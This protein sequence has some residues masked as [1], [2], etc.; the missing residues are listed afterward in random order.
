MKSIHLIFF[1]LFFLT[2]CR[3]EPL[4]IEI[5]QAEP[6]AVVFSQ[7]FPD[8]FLSLVLTNTLDA[9]DF[10]EEE[11]D[12]LNQDILSDL[13]LSGAYVTISYRDQLD[14]L[15][16]V[17]PGVYLS[18]ETPQYLNE[19][20]TLDILTPAGQRLS[21]KSQILPQA[22]F[23]SIQ[24]QVNRRATDTLVTVDFKIN[25]LPGDNWYLL[26]FYTNRWENAD[27]ASGLDSLFE[28]DGNFWKKTELIEDQFFAEGMIE[29][30]I[31]LPNVH[32]T[33][34]LFV[35]LSNVS[36]AY[37]RFLE[38]RKNAENLFTELTRE[39]VNSP[40][41][42]EGGLGFFNMHFPVLESFDLQEF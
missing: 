34:S 33:D 21:A 18:I 27:D 40:S 3:P 35:T 15:I 41:N 4:E 25:D 13:F 17:S 37:Y 29:G 14:P 42:I 5:P 26:H 11:G 19:T 8:Q 28:S 24:P 1:P 2:A 10:S 31:E 32:H 12:S 30:T 9:L 7:V 38:V 39:P 22:S 16:E 23:A 20:Y 6:Q 36:E